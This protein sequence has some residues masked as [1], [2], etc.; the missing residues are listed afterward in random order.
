MSNLLAI[1]QIGPWQLILCLAV[2]LL[3]FGGGRL[4]RL[5]RSLGASLTEF[6]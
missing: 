3:L 6:K 5:A 4:P 1:G 2:L